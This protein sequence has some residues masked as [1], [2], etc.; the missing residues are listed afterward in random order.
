MLLMESQVPYLSYSLPTSF[1][2]LVAGSLDPSYSLSFWIL[3]FQV[4]YIW[5]SYLLLAHSQG[6]TFL[7]TFFLSHP[8]SQTQYVFLLLATLVSLVSLVPSSYRWQTFSAL[9]CMQGV[10]ILFLWLFMGRRLNLLSLLG[11]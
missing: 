6:C 11:C 10:L 8:L 9:S 5:T 1:M 4:V 2:L 3:G 7:W